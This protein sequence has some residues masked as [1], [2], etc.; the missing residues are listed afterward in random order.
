MADWEKKEY[1]LKEN[2]QIN[3]TS[4]D[5]NVWNTN[6]F[7]FMTLSFKHQSVKMTCQYYFAFYFILL[8]QYFIAV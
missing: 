7:Q 1:L 4:K 2:I 3:L 5:Q 8:K 6:N